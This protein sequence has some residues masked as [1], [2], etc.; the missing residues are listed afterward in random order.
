[1]SYLVRAGRSQASAELFCVVLMCEEISQIALRSIGDAANQLFF[2]SA[3]NAALIALL[4]YLL[5][6]TERK[7]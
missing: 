3:D 2:C 1:M 6:L 5:G 4:P 7:N